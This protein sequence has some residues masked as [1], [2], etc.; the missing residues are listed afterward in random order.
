VPI[1]TIVFFVSW[2]ALAILGA[3]LLLRAWEWLLV[4]GRGWLLGRVVGFVFWLALAIFGAGLLILGYEEYVEP[5]S[6]L[7]TSGSGETFDAARVA[8]RESWDKW[9]G[10]QPKPDSTLGRA[11][12]LRLTTHLL[13]LRHF[14]SKGQGGIGMTNVVRLITSLARAHRVGQFELL[15]RE[16]N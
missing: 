10:G 4:F 6:G 9:R 5:R 16:I 14:R 11:D 3:S 12:N 13:D 8:F 1:E 15:K 2:L 7:R